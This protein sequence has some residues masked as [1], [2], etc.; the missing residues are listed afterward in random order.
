MCVSRSCRQ[1][2][3]K[4]CFLAIKLVF[5]SV[6]HDFVLEFLSGQ[7]FE[8]DDGGGWGG[9]DNDIRYEVQDDATSTHTHW[10]FGGVGVGGVGGQHSLF[11]NL[12][13]LKKK[14]CQNFMGDQ[15]R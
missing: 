9:R 4:C 14:K 3:T 1:H 13:A 11:T 8:Q 7:F 15:V 6:A 2:R 5:I 10:K 12:G